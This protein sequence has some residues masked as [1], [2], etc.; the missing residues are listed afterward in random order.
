M[1]CFLSTW[2][3]EVLGWN[4]LESSLAEKKQMVLN[5]FTTRNK[6]NFSLRMLMAMLERRD[7]STAIGQACGSNIS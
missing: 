6:E 4:N 3:Q 2:V 1:K 5:K 7:K